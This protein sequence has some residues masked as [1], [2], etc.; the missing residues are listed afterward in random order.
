MDVLQG[1]IVVETDTTD[2]SGTYSSADTYV[3]QVEI[4][5]RLKGPHVE[6]HNNETPDPDATHNSGP[7]TLDT[8]HDW[9]WSVDDPSPQDVETN[10]FYHV[11]F[12]HDWFLQGD[13]FDVSPWP[14]P[15]QVHVRIGE[16]CN[17]WAA[18]DGLT[19]YSGSPGGCLDYALGADIIYHEYVHRV[20]DK[21]YVIANVSYGSGFTGAMNEGLA[22]YFACSITNDSWNGEV[23]YEGR[24]IE[25]GEIWNQLPEG[26]NRRFPRDWV[27]EVHADGL[28]FNGAIWDARKVL[29]ADY[30][31]D[32]A[33]RA[34]KETPETFSGY[35]GA[36]LTTDD[37]DA[38]LANGTPNIATLCQAFY[39]NHGIFH[40]A[41]A[42]Y[43]ANLVAE[44]TS[45][46]LSEFYLIDGTVDAIL[47]L[48]SAYGSN[49]SSLASFKV[50]YA[51]DADPDNWLDVGIA[52]TGGGSVEVVDDL[53]ANWN[54][55][56]VVDGKY[57]IRL[58]VKDGSGA[59]STSTTSVV[60][61][62]SLHEGWPQL[63]GYWVLAS[64]VFGDLDPQYPGL[65][66]VVAAGGSVHAFHHDGTMVGGLW[67]YETTKNVSASPAIGDVDGD[68]SL[69]V[70]ISAW[71][72]DQA[73]DLYI[74]NSDGALYSPAWPLS[75]A[76]MTPDFIARPSSPALGDINDDGRSR[77]CDRLCQRQRVCNPPRWQPAREL[78]TT[79]FRWYRII[80]GNWRY[81][82]FLPGT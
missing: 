57:T 2:A 82:P 30:T 61:Q 68:G 28:I 58:T 39:D 44:I 70:V 63:T 16:G 12:I 33:M 51:S 26:N 74:L 8:T 77:D 34:L 37:D 9:N 64:P 66:V 55:T 42:G 46:S 49:T 22:D 43:T 80:A 72:V 29:G 4:M 47:V 35:L 67:P 25:T 45:P 53:L 41:C 38:D 11:N 62:R 31:D 54:L 7:L 48:G 27:G 14:Y 56:G 5:A 13:P 32:I 40:A 60:I 73:T 3:G 36:M 71:L 23:I 78:A 15:M 21:L 65:E 18:N 1:G 76:A 59:E 20:F 79:Y 75:I 10:V 69:E 19:F 81:R 50:E 52:L 24:D 6:V 17:A